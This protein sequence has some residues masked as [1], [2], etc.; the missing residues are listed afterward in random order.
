MFSIVLLLSKLIKSADATSIPLNLNSR[1]KR[2][3]IRKLSTQDIYF[4]LGYNN[5]CH[6]I[7][8]DMLTP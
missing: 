6:R 2:N 8:M 4:N 5:P 7:M 3:V 1:H